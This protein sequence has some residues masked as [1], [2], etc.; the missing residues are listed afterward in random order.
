MV[1]ALRAHSARVLKGN[2]LG[3]GIYIP[4][5]PR[6]ARGAPPSRAASSLLKVKSA[7]SSW[8]KCAEFDGSSPPPS[9][10]PLK[11]LNRTMFPFC[12]CSSLINK[13]SDLSGRPPCSCRKNDIPR[14][15]H[16]TP[17]QGTRFVFTRQRP[18]GV[19]CVVHRSTT[20]PKSI[21]KCDTK[22][23][24]RNNF[25]PWRFVRGKRRG[26]LQINQAKVAPA[27]FC[28]PISRCSVTLVPGS[29]PLGW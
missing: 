25:P 11:S 21:A 6:D 26:C 16:A 14:T 20:L 10:P 29:L 4:H 8:P 7:F 15:W 17:I 9:V 22:H 12:A 24:F 23:F 5:S 27:W 18:S 28:G 13:R 2:G 1:A 19:W 3:S